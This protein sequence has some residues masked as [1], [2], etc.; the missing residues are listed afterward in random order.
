[1]IGAFIF[2]GLGNQM[3]EYA[4]A[5][6]L[7]LRH[8]T[9]VYF[10]ISWFALKEQE[11]RP[12]L[13][14]VFNVVYKKSIPLQQQQFKVLIEI[15]NQ[16]FQPEVVSASDQ[17]CLIGLWQSEKYFEDY[18]DVIRSEL[19]LKIPLSEKSRVWANKIQNDPMPVS[20]HV[21]RGD[22]LQR[23]WINKFHQISLEYYDHAVQILKENFPNLTLYIF[24]D[25]LNWCRRIFNY[26]VPMNFV[27]GNDELHGYEDMILMSL[28]RHHI[29]ANST[30]SWWGAWLSEGMYTGKGS[31]TIAPDRYLAFYDVKKRILIPDRWIVLKS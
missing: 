26:D 4:T 18:A 29:I 3:F 19:T 31:I 20:L 11:A 14:D 6:A 24:S 8:K 22:Y 23:Q 9:D 13:L 10:D 12:Y 25:D 30:F 1:M 28:C 2:S 17:T 27:D 15:D 16:I 21:R 5:R 7:A